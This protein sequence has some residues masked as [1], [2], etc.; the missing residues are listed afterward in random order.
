MIKMKVKKKLGDFFSI[1]L[2]NGSYSYGRVLKDPLM[3]FYNLNN[4]SISDWKEVEKHPILFKVWTHENAIESGKWKIIGNKN[5]SNDLLESP[6]F[7]KQDQ[8]DN[9]I[10]KYKDGKEYPCKLED[11]TGLECAAIWSTTHIEDRLIDFFNGRVNKWVEALKPK[12]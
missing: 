2:S 9:E 12:L 4:S 10:T 7:Y 8:L 5:L 11:I 6:Y 3:G 1:P